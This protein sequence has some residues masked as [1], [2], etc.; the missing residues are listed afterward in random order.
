MGLKITGVVKRGGTGIPAEILFQIFRDQNAKR[1]RHSDADVHLRTD[2]GSFN[3]EFT[4]STGRPRDFEKMILV[5]GVLERS[6]I[7]P[8]EK[9]IEAREIEVQFIE[10]VSWWT[11]LWRAR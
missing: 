5:G 6:K 2:D 11:E 3:H 7:P 4:D 9:V 10:P 8:V 1:D